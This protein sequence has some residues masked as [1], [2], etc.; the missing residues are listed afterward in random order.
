MQAQKVFLSLSVSRRSRICLF[1]TAVAGP[2][3]FKSL[4]FCVSLEVHCRLVL[5]S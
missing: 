5:L 3:V 2:V 4:A 1:L